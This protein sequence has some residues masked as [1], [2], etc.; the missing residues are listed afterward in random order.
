[1]KAVRKKYMPRRQGN[2]PNM[3]T[4]TRLG[5]VLLQLIL[6][7]YS[8]FSLPLH[9]PLCLVSEKPDYF[10]KMSFAT[11]PNARFGFNGQ[12]PICDGLFKKNLRDTSLKLNHVA[13]AMLFR[14][15]SSRLVLFEFGSF[16][17]LIEVP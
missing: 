7:S 9:S 2:N 17:R 5:R 6:A 11:H 14:F 16:Q 12:P 8:G 3:A 15:A 4:S 10:A 13:M 1:V